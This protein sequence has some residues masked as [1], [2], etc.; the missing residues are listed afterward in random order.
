MNRLEVALEVLQRPSDFGWF[1]RDD[2]FETWGLTMSNAINSDDLI[3]ESNFIVACGILR[4]KFGDDENE[5][6]PNIELIGIK[7]WAVGSMDQIAVRVV[8]EDSDYCRQ[9]DM[10]GYQDTDLILNEDLTDE[11]NEIIDM[12]EEIEVY[13][14]LDENHY[15][16][17]EYDR[18]YDYVDMEY[19][20]FSD[21]TQGWPGEVIA[22]AHECGLDPDAGYLENEVV[23]EALV[24]VE[25]ADM[26]NDEVLEFVENNPQIMRRLEE[27]KWI[28]AGQQVFGL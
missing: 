5:F 28:D 22:F 19:A 4:D 6:G 18:T 24:W 10:G 14:L 21:G 8:R 23:I 20:N 11:F 27:K 13:P 1:G 3:N 17:L 7:H 16:E 9:I 12:M 26:D 15:S 25:M 2:M